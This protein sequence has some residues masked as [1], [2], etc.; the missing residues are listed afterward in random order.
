MY[1][2]SGI[3]VKQKFR[4]YLLPTV[5]TSMAISMASVVDG[6]IVGS[7]LG[8]TALAAIGLSSPIIFCIN[9]IY[10]LFAIGGLTCASIA[11]GKRDTRRANRI[12]TLS[13]GGGISAMLLFLLV[14]QVL[15]A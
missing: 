12:F 1:E 15:S 14:M 13:I 4:E 8:D 5:L 9:L 11:L 10:M 2:R 3:L 7:L 6:I